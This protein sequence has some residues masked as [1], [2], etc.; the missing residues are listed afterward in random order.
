MTRDGA[1]WRKWLMG[2][3]HVHL[4]AARCGCGELRCD[5]LGWRTG[6][7]TALL[8][9]YDLQFNNCHDPILDFGPGERFGFSDMNFMLMDGNRFDARNAEDATDVRWCGFC[10]HTG[11]G[12]PPLHLLP[13]ES[14]PDLEGATI[15]VWKCLDSDLSDVP[16]LKFIQEAPISHALRVWIS[17]GV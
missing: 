8:L 17:E 12:F 16:M 14:L 2:G 5:A 1:R 4:F 6:W 13:R 15:L 9:S 3:G 11:R 7:R 10:F